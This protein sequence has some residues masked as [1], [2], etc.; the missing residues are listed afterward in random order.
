MRDAHAR[1]AKDH[2][3]KQRNESIDAS[4]NDERQEGE[5]ELLAVALA[6]AL[7]VDVLLQHRKV[8]EREEDPAHGNRQLEL[9]GQRHGNRTADTHTLGARWRVDPSRRSRRDRLVTAYI[10]VYVGLRYITMYMQLRG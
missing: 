7:L 10:C 5:G 2:H 4:L 8:R 3:A 9:G 1:S 6:V